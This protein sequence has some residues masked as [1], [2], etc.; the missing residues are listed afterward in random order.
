MPIIQTN[1]NKTHILELNREASE[2]IV[3]IHGMFTN[4]SI[5]YFN[6]AP[7]LAKKYHVVL[8]DLRSHGLS[9]RIDHGY[10]L[11]TLTQDLLDILDA[12]KLSQVDLVGYSF[13]GIIAL[14]TAI[15]F[16]EKV[17]KL[18]VI[19]SP[20]TDRDGETERIIEKFGDEF[21][22]HYMKNYSIST[23]LVPSKRQLEKNKKLYHFLLHETSMPQ[24]LVKDKQFSTREN[25]NQVQQET[26][27]LYGT[28]SDCLPDGEFLKSCIPNSTLFTGKGDHNI[29]V[30]N[31]E[32]IN[33]ELSV[34][35]S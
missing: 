19:E 35:F 11:K 15:H 2:T 13:G 4:S 33:K 14:Y 16:P 12:M 9:E 20:I 34:F 25:M 6:I 24:D 28:D 29:P 5:F 31:P 18:A 22:E 17:K 26:L 30:Q 1:N 23:N 32:W 3:M 21:L 7:E 10:D 27:L 8:Y